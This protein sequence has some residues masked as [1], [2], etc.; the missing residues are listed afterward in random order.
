MTNFC[1]ECGLTVTHGQKFCAG[2]GTKIVSEQPVPDALEP[3]Y[4][5]VQPSDPPL[6]PAHQPLKHPS[7]KIQR[8][9]SK[10]DTP[11]A[12]HKFFWYVSLPIGFL[13]S[14]YRVMLHFF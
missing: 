8:Y 11:L 4:Q 14:L 6:M 1:P 2:C 7:G 13:F 3:S 12:F 10:E 9:K 5:S